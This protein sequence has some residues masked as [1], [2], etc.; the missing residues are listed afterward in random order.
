MLFRCAPQAPAGGSAASGPGTVK[1]D[2]KH[3]TVD[4]HCHLHVPE[5][6]EIAPP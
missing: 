6:D 3:L 4:I 2:R 1:R 5:A